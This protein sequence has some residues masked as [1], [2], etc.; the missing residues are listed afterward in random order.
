MT[1]DEKSDENKADKRS[2]ELRF[3]AHL[4]PHDGTLR[5]QYV[6]TDP[7]GSEHEVDETRAK[8]ALHAWI[9]T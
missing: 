1:S 6:V 8:T 3:T 4:P 5:T 2:R 9:D 7:G